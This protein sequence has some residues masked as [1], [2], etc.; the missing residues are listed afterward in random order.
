MAGNIGNLAIVISANAAPFKAALISAKSA[1]NDF[2]AQVEQEQRRRAIIRPS[3]LL[4][5]SSNFGAGNRTAGT[6]L[7]S[8]LA[9]GFSGGLAGSLVVAVGGA[10]KS[11]V[12]VAGDIGHRAGEFLAE[13]FQEGLQFKRM[14]MGVKFLAGS[15]ERGSAW[16][17]Q[18]RSLSMQS[19]YG[20]TELGAGLR[21]IAGSTDDLDNTI[22]RLRAIASIGA[23]IG[24][25]AENIRLF[26][27]AIAQVQAAGR[28]EAQ[29][30]NQLTEHGLP[31]K[32][33]AKTAG[34]SVGEFRQ[35]VKDGAVS[36]DVLDKTLNRL[37]YNEGG[38]FFGIL[39]DR[40]KTSIGQID[41]IA[42]SFQQLKIGLGE[43]ILKGLDEGGFLKTAQSGVEFFISHQSQFSAF[44]KEAIAFAEQFSLGLIR[45]AGNLYDIARGFRGMYE[46]WKPI[47]KGILWTL[48]PGA[49]LATQA[50]TRTG[51]TGG[52]WERSFQDFIA[53]SRR[54]YGGLFNRVGQAAA[55]EKGGISVTD[56]PVLDKTLAKMLEDN[57]SAMMKGANPFDEFTNSLKQIQAA[58]DFYAKA[59]GAESLRPFGQ[60][61]QDNLLIQSFMQLEK[62]LSNAVVAFPKAME[63][64]S[65]EAASAI[66]QAMFGTNNRSVIDVLRDG[67]AQ[68]KEQKA[69]QAAQLE[70]LKKL[71]NEDG[72]LTFE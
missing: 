20:M 15:P 3:S 55:A 61:E 69:I 25:D 13:S 7:Q 26:A 58:K 47:V 16:M 63:A 42:A 4:A 46:D 54:D 43:G 65:V 19:G 2:G 53:N 5:K 18:L 33:L 48:N 12:G 49:M 66:N 38:K 35:Q 67:L 57:R 59:G 21:Q 23:G 40:A 37:V 22:P 29:E 62:G 11:V 34:L 27:L 24:L 41:R 30:L 31:I 50:A 36:V 39:A 32:E 60:L 51:G 56:H 70:E 71:V 28:F 14:E 1:I 10:L 52:E 72:V 64:G 68:A 44:F 45:V 8:T 6:S 17:S 9:A